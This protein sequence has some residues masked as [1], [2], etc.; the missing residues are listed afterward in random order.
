MFDPNSPAYPSENDQ[1]RNRKIAEALGYTL[2]TQNSFGKQLQS[3]YYG[4]EKFGFLCYA[5]ALPDFSKPEWQ[6]KILAKVRSMVLVRE[7]DELIIR[8]RHSGVI[9][10]RSNS[11]ITFQA[12]TDREAYENYLL[13][14]HE[15]RG[16]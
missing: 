1:E 2:C 6:I 7:D 12:D 9:L 13:W 8:Y 14:L 3:P 10:G 15:R 16:E 5:D 11:V 4:S